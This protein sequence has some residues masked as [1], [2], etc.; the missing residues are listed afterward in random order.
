MAFKDNWPVH[1]TAALTGDGFSNKL[2][3]DFWSEDLFNPGVMVR[4]HWLK[5]VWVFCVSGL[6]QVT[7]PSVIVMI[8]ITL[9]KNGGSDWTWASIAVVAGT[10]IAWLFAVV[11]SATVWMDQKRH[12]NQL[13]RDKN[14]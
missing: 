6:A 9:Y 1:L 13:Q 12:V 14:L 11:V 7:L 3:Q 8:P 2:A 5:L 4:C 10:A